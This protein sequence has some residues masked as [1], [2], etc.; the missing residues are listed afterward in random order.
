MVHWNDIDTV[1]LDMDGT[2]LD[3]HFDNHFWLEHLP[4]RYAEI[5][6]EDPAEARHRMLER[7]RQEQGTLNWYCVDYW[8]RELGLDVAA[9]KDE[10]RHLI[11]I[12]PHVEDFLARL[13]AGH[14]RVLLVTNA[15]RKS[16]DLKMAH[17]G[18]E[19]WFDAIVSSHDFGMA[20]EHDGFWDALRAVEPF[21]P[22]RTLF[23]DD[24]LSVLESARRYG[25]R[26]LL[27]LLQP[28]SKR[29]PRTV[30][31]FPAILHFDEI[32]PELERIDA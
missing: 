1:L 13:H 28:D 25:I 14:R 6:G 32:M 22:A 19:R 9:L 7:F 21:D 16:L 11:R 15:H 3:L 5:H 24:S 30:E 4:R 10:L 27:C 8:T 2:L 26:W 18:L 17:T 29:E 20:K 23:I 12:R 31:G